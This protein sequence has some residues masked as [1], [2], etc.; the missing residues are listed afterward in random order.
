[1]RTF[2]R[3]SSS[4]HQS[5]ID[6]VSMYTGLV[7]KNVLAAYNSAIALRKHF[8]KYGSVTRVY[9][10]PNKSSATVKFVDHVSVC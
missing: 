5:A 3:R 8:S 6:D 2:S 10:N 7:C 1:M 4:G 9:P